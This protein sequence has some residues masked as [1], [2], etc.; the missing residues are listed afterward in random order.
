MR[1][2]ANGVWQLGGFPPN[3]V[4]TYLLEDVLIDAGTRFDG[5]RILRQLEGR[6]VAAHA[7]THAHP[8]HQGSSHEVCS[9]L[10]IPFWVGE[11]DAGVAE[12]P[13]V[14]EGQL[15]RNPFSGTAIPSNPLLHL[16][17]GLAAGR[18]HAV[19]RRLRGGDQVAGFEVIDAPGH[20]AGQVVFWRQSDRVLIA[21]D[22]VWNIPRLME[23]LP[24]VS[25]DPS[26]NRAAAR[27]LAELEPS[28]VCFG[29]GPPLRDTRKFVEFVATLPEG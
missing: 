3:L 24:F 29:H 19:A 27:R 18:G 5:S 8:D 9:R 14:M 1:Q 12:D 28:L 6:P 20:T 17:V 13:R 26:L 7:L 23:P 15:L 16:L 2:L 22:V 4:N 10:G 21:G 25:V 11:R